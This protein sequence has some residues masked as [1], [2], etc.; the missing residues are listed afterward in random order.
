[1]THTQSE[2]SVVPTIMV[3]R[4]LAGSG[5]INSNIEKV[6]S[7]IDSATEDTPLSLGWGRT[8]VCPVG[9][10]EPALNTAEAYEMTLAE[11]GNDIL[12][13]QYPEQSCE[14]SRAMRV[15]HYVLQTAQECGDIALIVLI[16]TNHQQTS[17][18]R[19]ALAEGEFKDKVN[20]KSH[21]EVIPRH[22]AIL[23]ED[24]EITDVLSPS[25]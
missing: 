2:P 10:D 12:R 5:D 19:A 20:G 13:V 15:L 8:I 9:Q 1:M 21:A 24:G 7:I 18:L 11:K 17:L 6:H 16:C 23:I 3:S 14:Q 25:N 4:D 22:S